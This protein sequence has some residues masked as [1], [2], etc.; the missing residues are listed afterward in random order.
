[1]PQ[2]YTGNPDA[3]Q[4]PAQVP[5]DGA[6]PVLALPVGTD[7]PTVS[8]IYQPLKV[9][10]DYMAYQQARGLQQKGVSYYNAT[11][12]YSSPDMVMYFV[13]GRR[14]TYI[15]KL[16]ADAF[17]NVAPPDSDHWEKWYLTPEDC[18]I[19]NSTTSGGNVGTAVLPGGLKL[20]WEYL[21]T[22]DL[23]EASPISH[24]FASAFASVAFFA[25]VIPAVTSGV[26]SGVLAGPVTTTGCTLRQMDT[27]HLTTSGMLISV[28]V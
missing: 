11:R 4:L 20:Q 17:S 9:L 7:V 27:S 21:N 15:A 25:F 23:P 13:D 22:S 2:N 10:A 6:A 14:Q 16:G 19:S 5:A 1:M 18:P 28:G 24:T 3:H 26:A 12:T 8:S